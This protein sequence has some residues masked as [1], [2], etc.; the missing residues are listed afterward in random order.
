MIKVLI[1]DF[2]GAFSLSVTVLMMLTSCRQPE[3]LYATNSNTSLEDKVSP[4]T[5]SAD[6]Y[7]AGDLM[8]HMPQEASAKNKNGTYSFDPWFKLIRPLIEG[9]DLALTNLELTFGGKPY[10]GYPSFSAPDTLVYTLKRVGFDALTTANNHSADRGSR[11]IIRTIDVLNRAAMLHA[12][13]FRSPSERNN[14][15]PLVLEKNGLRFAVLAYTYGTNGIRVQPPAVVNYIDDKTLEEVKAA[16]SDKDIDFVIVAIHWGIEYRRNFSR[17]QAVWAQKLVDAGANIVVG[18][19]PHVVQGS[20]FLKDSTGREALVLYSM[21]NYISN[22]SSNPN[23]RGGLS[24]RFRLAKA[25][26]GTK[27]IKDLRYI[28]TWVSMHDPNGKKRYLIVPISNDEG[29][30]LSYV[31]A[32]EK[33]IFKA[34]REY[35]KKIPLANNR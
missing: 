32:D 25:K 23:T 19:H 12:G 26:S 15:T 16:A 1:R 13:T 35:A 31:S 10:S 9:A 14:L 6:F 4:D 18:S 21:G 29:K 34:Y 11:G 33:P 2:I 30:D 7:F 28:H 20:E 22:Q 27:E 24:V 8:M 17:E 5:L 3:K